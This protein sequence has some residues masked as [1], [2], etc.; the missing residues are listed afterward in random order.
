MS[1]TPQEPPHALA[2]NVEPLR[3]STLRRRSMW[4]SVLFVIIWVTVI[5]LIYVG[6]PLLLVIVLGLMGA[7]IALYDRTSVRKSARIAVLKKG[8]DR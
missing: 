4:L 8:C 2:S 5:G 1:S 3:Q 6:G 7:F